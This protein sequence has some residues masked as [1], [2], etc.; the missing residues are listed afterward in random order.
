MYHTR[1][2]Y[3]GSSRTHKDCRRWFRKAWEFQGQKRSWLLIGSLL[4][5]VM[6]LTHLQEWNLSRKLRSKMWSNCPFWNPGNSEF[7]GTG[8][9]VS[10]HTAFKYPWF[11][12]SQKFLL[13]STVMTDINASTWPPLCLQSWIRLPHSTSMPGAAESFMLAETSWI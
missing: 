7:S 4:C 2:W 8:A 11:N 3:C 13:R 10:C 12:A 5:Y 1:E 6:Y 9:R